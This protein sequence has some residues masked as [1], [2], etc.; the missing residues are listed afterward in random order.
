MSGIVPSFRFKLAIGWRP[1]ACRT[2]SQVASRWLAV[3]LGQWVG[4]DVRA[5]NEGFFDGSDIE[6]IAPDRT[7]ADQRILVVRYKT[8]GIATRENIAASG[9]DFSWDGNFANDVEAP[10]G[11]YIFRVESFNN[12]TSLATESD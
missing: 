6:L 11:T 12:G 9:T 3:E 10:H 5:E 1:R 8:G 4:M 7:D 2:N